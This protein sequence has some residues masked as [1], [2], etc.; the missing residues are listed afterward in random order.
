VIDPQDLIAVFSD[1]TDADGNGYVDDIAGW[2]FH[3][4]DN[5]PSTTSP[6]GTVR[7]RPRTRAP[8]RRTAASAPRRTRRSSRSR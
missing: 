2:D 8:K 1:A 7:A 3:E 6:T 4:D 5:D